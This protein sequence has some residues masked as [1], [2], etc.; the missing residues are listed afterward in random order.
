MRALRRHPASLRQD[1]IVK[2]AHLYIHVPFCARR[3]V[4]CDFSI[5]VRSKVP[6]ADFVAAVAK[7]WDVRHG[8]SVFALDTL[9][10]GGGTPSKLGADGVA[11]LMDVVRS[12]AVLRADAEVTLE[13]NPEDVTL[14]HVNAWRSAGVNR[15]SLGVQS[16]D[17]SVLAWMH[18]THDALTALRAIQVLREGGLDNIS[19]DLIFAAPSQVTRVWENDVETAVG[20]GLPHLS[21]YGL[22]VEPHTPLGRWVARQDVHEAPEER[23]EREYLIAHDSLTGAGL[24]HYEVSNYGLPGR[25]SRH[26]WAY[27]RRRPYAGLGPSAHEFD[28]AVR[29]WNTAPYADWQLRLAGGESTTIGS[30]SLDRDQQLAEEVYLGLRT[31]DGI[32]LTGEEHL[33]VAPWMDAGWAV[34]TNENSMRLT[35]TGWL[36]LDTLASDLTLLRSH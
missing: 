35:A 9:Y 2:A 30:E 33:H 16:F 17:D 32:S 24:D 25:H 14:D 31:S 28:G 26:N 8:D 34:M 5:A 7:E 36:R 29:R 15:V 27:W 11:R 3:C 10:F 4:Y 18:R 22:T 6:T 1:A 12:R 20:I 19:I 21:V 13:A 23:F